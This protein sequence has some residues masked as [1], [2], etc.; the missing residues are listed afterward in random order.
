V[1]DGRLDDMNERMGEEFNRPDQEI[2][3]VRGEIRDVRTEIRE[4][5]ADMATEF[6]AVRMEMGANHRIMLQLSV[7]TI[8]TMAIG[9]L[10]VI[11]TQ[12]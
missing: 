10:G 12:L 1:D 7:G 3:D 11:V 5:R 8:A 2:R 6:A 9:F 4:F